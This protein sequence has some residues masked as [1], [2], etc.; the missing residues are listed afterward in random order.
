MLSEFKKD[1]EVVV[2]LQVRNNQSRVYGTS[3]INSQIFH[4]IKVRSCKK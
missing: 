1:S 4:I 2:K 3:S